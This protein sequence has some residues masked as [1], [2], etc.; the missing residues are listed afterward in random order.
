MSTCLDKDELNDAEPLYKKAFYFEYKGQKNTPKFHVC[1]CTAIDN[2][3]RE[4]YR[5]D[6]AEP[7]KVFSKNEKKEVNVNGL[8]LCGFCRN[9][10]LEDERYRITNSTDFVDILKEVGDVQEPTLVELDFY[11]YVKDWE[12]ISLA[13]RTKKNF[14][15]ERCGIQIDD[16]FDRSFIHT[17]HRNG[18]KTDNRELNLECLC[19][20]CHSEIDE[21]HEQNFLRGGNKVLLENFYEKYH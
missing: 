19:I 8:E 7:I 14:T 21:V 13:Y 17:H 2:Y 3:G 20:K 15:C 16:P 11:G 12:Q 6:N 1:Q 4:A 10:L 5:F 9:L 18:D